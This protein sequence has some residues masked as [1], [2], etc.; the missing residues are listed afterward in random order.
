MSVFRP[1]SRRGVADP[2]FDGP[3]EGLPDYLFQPC[4]EW[5]EELLWI[6]N[7]MRASGY[8]PNLEFLKAM[9]LALRL[10]PPLAWGEDGAFVVENLQRRM[11]QDREFALDVLDF[12]VQKIA[13]PEYADKL[14]EVLTLGGSEW[15]V[16]QLS[17]EERHLAQRVVGPVRA[18]IEALHS[19]SERAHHH[20]SVAWQKLVGRNPDP[21]GS[22]REAIRAV[23]AVAKPVVTPTDP[24]ATLGKIIRAIRDKPEKWIVA[25]DKASPTQI[26]DM[27]D[28]IW[29]GQQDR[30]GTDDPKAALNV[31]QHEADA[32]VHIALALARLFASGGIRQA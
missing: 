25:L 1:L 32:A 13:R 21:S 3:Q 14:D 18:S 24:N 4:W 31:T 26:A 27:A 22:Y 9:Q 8:D 7:P 2:R 30:H 28:L 15:E 19:D 12:F 17:G 6:D 23:E 5:L 11:V 29:K 10:E 20:L 16:A